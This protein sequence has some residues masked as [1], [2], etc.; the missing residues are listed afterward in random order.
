MKENNKIIPKDK[1][2]ILCIFFSGKNEYNRY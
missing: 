2:T 1:E